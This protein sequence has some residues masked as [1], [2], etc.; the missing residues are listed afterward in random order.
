MSAGEHRPLRFWLLALAA[1]LAS[2]WLLSGM[3][4][5]FVLGIA[6][7]YLLDPIV[8]RC[9]RL[10][11]PRW[12][13]TL[14]AL[15]GFAVGI[16]GTVVLLVPLSKVQLL[17]LAD[18]LPMLVERVRDEMV[19][20]LLGLVDRLRPEDVE[21]LRSAATEYAGVVV[22]WIGS[23]LTGLLSRGFAILDVVSVLVITPVVAFYLLRDWDLIVST[24]D[25][26][27]PRR[28]A[29]LI[30]AEVREV[31]RTLAG[32]V[33]GQSA[34]CVILGAYY[35]VVL[36]LVGL[37]FGLSIGVVV[38]VLSI[39]PYFGSAVGL[40]ASVSLA[41]AQYDSWTMVGVVAGLFLFGQFIEGNFVTPRL[42][43]GSVGLHP[44]WVMFALLAGGYL[45]G[46]LGVLV[47]VPVAAVVGVGT[48]FALRQYL[49]SAYFRG[50]GADGPGG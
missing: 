44:V 11:L 4:L 38:G 47:A 48:R 35:A 17:R 29:D 43:G 12:A 28:N 22:L 13:G 36:T 8:D 15:C 42:V 26:W 10:G 6:I 1:T 2:L 50:R 18:R 21:R 33:R 41:I 14:L 40:L 30:R 27:L 25:G 34:V 39:I 37:D 19:P 23:F 24:V 45:F 3:L 16:A 49:G 7:A 31:D 5:P 20:A 46:F 9:A 32:F